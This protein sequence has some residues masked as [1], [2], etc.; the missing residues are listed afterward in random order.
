M[1]KNTSVEFTE[2]RNF[3]VLRLNEILNEMCATLAVLSTNKDANMAIMSI[4]TQYIG[5]LLVDL[6][7]EDRKQFLETVSLTLTESVDHVE[8]NNKFDSYGLAGHA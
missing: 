4:M 3:F 2:A 6:P 5:E 1:F 7:E 8:F